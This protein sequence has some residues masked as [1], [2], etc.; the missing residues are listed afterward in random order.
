MRQRAPLA[1][2]DDALRRWQ[3]VFDEDVELFEESAGRRSR[4]KRVTA[5]LASRG[6]SASA[7][8][9]STT[10]APHAASASQLEA[11]ATVW[12]A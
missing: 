12:H 11:H 7:A 4:L 3:R 10:S 5:A 8:T 2:L 1:H 6:I 9:L